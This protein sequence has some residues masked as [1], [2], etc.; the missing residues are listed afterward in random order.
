M[1]SFSGLSIDGTSSRFEETQMVNGQIME[2]EPVWPDFSWPGHSMLKNLVTLSLSIDEGDVIFVE[3]N[4]CDL[5]FNIETVRAK[6]KQRGKWP[7]LAIFIGRSG[8]I[9]NESLDIAE[10]VVCQLIDF[11]KYLQFLNRE[12][13]TLIRMCQI[14]LDFTQKVRQSLDQKSKN[15]EPYSET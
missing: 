15:H 2:G 11:N 8:G 14:T 9:W 1:A 10:N 6:K 5:A 13:R 4:A 3:D 7:D 12:K